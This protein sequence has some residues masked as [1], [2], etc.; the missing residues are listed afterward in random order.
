M[1]K[2][3]LQNCLTYCQEQN[4]IPECKNC[5]LSQEDIDGFER[6]MRENERAQMRQ[7]LREIDLIDYYCKCNDQG[8]VIAM[9]RKAYDEF[10]QTLSPRDYKE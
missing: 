2:K 1:T 10:L 7:K 3:E 5:G 6:E 4:G 9:T 8:H